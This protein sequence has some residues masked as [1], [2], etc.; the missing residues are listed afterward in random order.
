MQHVQLVESGMR[1]GLKENN[2]GV[3]H[4]D[5]KKKTMRV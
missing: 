4:K 1:G 2:L 5:V 3:T